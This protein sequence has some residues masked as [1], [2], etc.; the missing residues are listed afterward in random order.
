MVVAALLC[1]SVFAQQQTPVTSD[2]AQEQQKLNTGRNTWNTKFFSN[3]EYH[4]SQA[5]TTCWEG[6]YPWIVQITP[7]QP[8]AAIDSKNVY[9]AGALSIAQTFDKIQAH[10]NN[11]NDKVEAFYDAN[12]G[13]PTRYKIQV[14]AGTDNIVSASVFNFIAKSS[15]PKAEYQTNRNLWA[16]QRIVN[17]DFEYTDM[18]P[19]T[20]NIMWPLYVKVR[21]NVIAETKDSNGNVVL[22]SHPTLLTINQWFDEI[23]RQLDSGSPYMDNEYNSIKGYAEHIHAVTYANQQTKEYRFQNYRDTGL[24]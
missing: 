6:N 4:F 5:C 24:S 10:L 14:G 3:Y 20:D 8:A 18:G 22:W 13:Y 2:Q 15:D 9:R 16:N 17:Y 11:P 12:N 7:G 23:K 21:N 19:N 1:S